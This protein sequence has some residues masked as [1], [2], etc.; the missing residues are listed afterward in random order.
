MIVVLLLPMMMH[1]R[2]QFAI[3][4]KETVLFS[5]LLENYNLSEHEEA[6]PG[7]LFLMKISWQANKVN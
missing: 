2:P 4:F 5:K 1:R 6:N 7:H 3:D